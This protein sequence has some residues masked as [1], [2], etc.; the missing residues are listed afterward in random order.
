M[1]NSNQFGLEF[2]DLDFT[3]DDRKDVV[4]GGKEHEWGTGIQL[5]SPPNV[6]HYGITDLEWDPS[7]RF[8]AT[9]ASVWRHS[10][11]LSCFFSL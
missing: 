8:V 3:M 9:S 1:G 11:S 4:P 10:V 5:L 7:G 6:E 2:W